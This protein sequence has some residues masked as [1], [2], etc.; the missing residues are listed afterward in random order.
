MA[1]VRPFRWIELVGVILAD[2]Q[3]DP[4]FFKL[5][6]T[7][8]TKLLLKHITLGYFIFICPKWLLTV[9]TCINQTHSYR[10]RSAVAKCIDR[11]QEHRAGVKRWTTADRT[12]D[13]KSNLQS[14][15]SSESRCDPEVGLR[16]E[17]EVLQGSG[18]DLWPEGGW[19]NTSA[20]LGRQP[21]VLSQRLPVPNIR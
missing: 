15:G 20:P 9:R 19:G 12:S 14:V 18:R 8:S 5:H 13:W 3:C 10:Q 17:G 11:V 16:G 2:R 4:L 21:Y 6:V 1:S 7:S